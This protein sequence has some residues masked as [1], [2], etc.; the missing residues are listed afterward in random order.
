MG[1]MRGQLSATGG[2]M[3]SAIARFAQPQ[4][5]TSQVR[6]TAPRVAKQVSAQISALDG[7]SAVGSVG[8]VSAQGCSVLCAADWL[9]S[10]RFVSIGLGEGPALQAVVRWVR[11]GLA[12]LEFLRAVPSDRRDWRALMDR[13]S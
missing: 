4:E 7:T 12:G 6:R 8:D 11:G 2:Q 3:V 10:G 5:A 9:R 13:D 1:H